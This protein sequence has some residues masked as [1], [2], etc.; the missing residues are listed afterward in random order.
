MPF[1]SASSMYFIGSIGSLAYGNEKEGSC[2]TVKAA[3][4]T[5]YHTKSCSYLKKQQSAWDMV[6][7]FFKSADRCQI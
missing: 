7:D 4:P 2:V 6:E 3:V 1:C 5:D